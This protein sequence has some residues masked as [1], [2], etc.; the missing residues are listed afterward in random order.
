MHAL[1][2]PVVNSPPR[3]HAINQSVFISSS[4]QKNTPSQDPITGLFEIVY[5]TTDLFQPLQ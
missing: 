3:P 2:F 5:Y 4:I 1:L